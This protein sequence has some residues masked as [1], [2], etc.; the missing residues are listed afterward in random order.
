MN[1]PDLKSDIAAQRA[2]ED[3]CITNEPGSADLRRALKMQ[4][5]IENQHIELSK[6]DPLKR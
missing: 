6:N 4:R 3:A 5:D 1:K 2:L